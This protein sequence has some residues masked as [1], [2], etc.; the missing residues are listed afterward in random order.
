MPRFSSIRTNTIRIS[1]YVFA[2]YALC[3]G[4]ME[5]GG[6]GAPIYKCTVGSVYLYFSIILSFYPFLLP[7][8]L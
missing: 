6:G 5:G 2:T 8:G 3:G 1:I 7:S 4:G